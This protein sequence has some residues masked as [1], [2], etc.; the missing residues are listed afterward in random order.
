MSLECQAVKSIN[1]AVIIDGPLERQMLP[2]SAIKQE[3]T[4]L[5]QGEFTIRFP[6]DKVIDGGWTL[7]GIQSVIDQLMNDPSVDMILANGLLASHQAAKNKA[8]AKPVIATVIADRVVQ[9][10]PYIDG[11]SGKHNFV[12]ISDNRSV[13]DDLRRFHALIPF[14]HLVIPVDSSILQALP[15]LRDT[16]IKIQNE[17]G[18]KLSIVP[19]YDTLDE[20]LE[21]F[22]IDCD[23]V[24][25]P[26]IQRFN[27]TQIQVFANALI[28]RKIASFS[29]MGKENLELGFLSTLSRRD[30]NILRFS[31]RIALNVQSIL[32]GTNAANLPVALSQPVNLSINMKTARAIGFS[33]NWLDLEAAELLFNDQTEEIESIT[34]IDAMKRAV[35]TN[36]DLQVSSLNPRLA[37]NQVKAA[38]SGLLPQLNLGAGYSLINDERAG[39]Q[40]AERSADAELS[41]SQLVYS[42]RSWSDF[43]VARLLKDAEDSA[44]Q[45]RILDVMRDSATSYLQVLLSRAT[46][47]I[48]ESNLRVS[49]ANLELARNRLAIGYSDRSDVLRWESEIATDQSSVYQATASREQAETELKRQLNMPLSAL[50]KVTDD[51]VT[52]LINVLDSVR[53][54]R[55]FD[56][57]KHF[58]IFTRFE[59]QR[60]VDN[61]PELSQ[62]RAQIASSQ[63]QLDASKRI[64]YVPDVS[65]NVRYNRNLSR[66]G[67]G[68]S[69]P[70][71][72][73]NDWSANLQASLPLF[74]G[75]AR[76]AEVSRARNSLRQ[77]QTQHQAQQQQIEARVLS[78]IQRA[79]GS[80]PA[81]RLARQAARAA[82]DNFELI[83]DA[84]VKGAISIT[85]LIDAQDAALAANLATVEAQ[86]N[87][88]IDWIAIQRAIAN[89][90]VLLSED[91]FDLWYSALDNY[92]RSNQNHI[93]P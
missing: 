72:L 28:D 29:M 87:F 36:L 10:L 8:L 19:I 40:Q 50:I 84:Y 9:K 89:Y 57:P 39:L 62:V 23:A 38:R 41:L 25:A 76:Q 31:R 16:T 33:P 93:S 30:N 82:K 1:V 53:F 71:L 81:V 86:Y 43:D 17:L 78:A 7:S 5:T 24:Y 4:D 22:P 2:L 58:Q 35:A 92:Y 88:V 3:M 44:Y 66:N 91:G 67:V 54:K 32:L 45:S 80:Y 12:Y 70:N 48:R 49:Q 42:E 64:Y 63:R 74:A 13:D 27:S 52:E 69:S 26:P 77:S 6:E 51:G 73:D 11:H 90:D 75:G 60:A 61:A 37:A 59:L 47:K 18:F 83:T 14:K 21:R 55:F 46:E 79:K 68:A 56:T 34:L 15:E 65:V 20:V 85:N